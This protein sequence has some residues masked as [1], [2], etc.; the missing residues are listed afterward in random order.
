MYMDL[1]KKLNRQEMILLTVFVIYL[2]GNFNLPE[3]INDLIDNTF[4]NVAVILVALALFVNSSPVLGIIGFLVAYELIRR[5]SV[6]TGTDAIERYLPSEENK[7]KKMETYQP[8]QS[9][10]D[11]TLEEEM[12]DN[13]I[14]FTEKNDIPESNVK[15][16]LDNNYGAEV[17]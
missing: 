15:P 3:S 14:E 10:P 7:A 6:S 4:G 13:I 16:I 1:L 5:A 2:I 12:V 8:P 9:T 11:V 17:L